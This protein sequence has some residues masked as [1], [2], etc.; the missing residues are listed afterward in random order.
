MGACT[1]GICTTLVVLRQ[2][3][4][5]LIQVTDIDGAH[6]GAD[7]E[8][9]IV[10]AGIVVDLV[11]VITGLFAS[12]HNT[13]AAARRIA[14]IGAGIGI[15]SIAIVTLFHPNSAK[16]V[17]AGGNKAGVKAVVG[18]VTI[19]IVADFKALI[20]FDEVLAGDRITTGRYGADVGAGVGID[21]V[22]VITGFTR[23]QDGV[24]TTSGA[25]IVHAA[26]VFDLVAVVAVFPHRLDAIATARRLA[27]VG[28]GIGIETIAVIA[29]LKVFVFRTEVTPRDAVTAARRSTGSGAGILIIGISIIADLMSDMHGSVTATRHRASA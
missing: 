14:G 12:A 2:R 25:A 8:G 20:A 18:I 5:L 17:A 29:G 23:L 7:A 22:A 16:A 21:P 15:D 3:I 13:I 26:I 27:V 11:A 9:A 24:A 28:A 4:A 10:V 6:I 19:T 1:V